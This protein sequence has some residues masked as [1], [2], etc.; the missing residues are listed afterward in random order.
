MSLPERFT[1]ASSDRQR[2]STPKMSVYSTGGGHLNAAAVRQLW[3]GDVEAFIIGSDPES[4][5]IAF[6]EADPEHD[7]SYAFSSDENGAGG[8]V[9]IAPALKEL[10]IDKDDIEETQRFDLEQ[11]GDVVLADISALLEQTGDESVSD[12]DVED[13]SEYVT[14]DEVQETV[15]EGIEEA[16]RQANRRRGQP[17]DEGQSSEG[18]ESEKS[19]KETNDATDSVESEVDI[20]DDLERDQKVRQW[21]DSQLETGQ[22]LETDATT[23]AEAIDEDG[24]GIPPSL[25]RLDGYVVESEQRDPPTPNLWR[26]HRE[27]EDGEDADDLVLEDV[28]RASKDEARFWCGRCGKGPFQTDGQVEGHHNRNGH[29]GDYVVRAVQPTDNELLDEPGSP[30]TGDGP[31][32]ERLIEMLDLET[33][34]SRWFKT[35]DFAIGLD[36]RGNDVQEVLEELTPE[37][38]YRVERH[39]RLWCIDPVD[40]G[41]DA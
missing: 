7:R 17:A 10:G 33:P 41:G 19:E 2:Q 8:D 28:E 23:I 9:T 18:D 40:T 15:R 29:Q 26:I 3:D 22:T 11:D 12:D 31:L 30:D 27:E 16:N 1:V 4:C 37:D 32:K 21:L 6:V 39:D 13:D 14:E 38:G 5:E 20:D 25:K 36:E 34:E 24:R 35:A